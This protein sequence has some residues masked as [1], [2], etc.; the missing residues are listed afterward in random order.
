MPLNDWSIRRYQGELFLVNHEKP[1]PESPVSWNGAQQ[2]CW[3][4][5]QVVFSPTQG[6]GIGSA[7]LSPDSVRLARRQGGEHFRPEP[8]RPRRTLK[9]LLQEARVAPWEREIMPLLWWRGRPRVGAG[10]RRGLRHQCRPD[11]PGWSV[12]WQ[13]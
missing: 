12:S 11:E 5:T 2:L 9:K 1:V 3:G 13:R 4:A 10:S 6:E 7:R 8:R